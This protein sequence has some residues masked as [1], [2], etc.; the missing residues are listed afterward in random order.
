LKRT[1]QVVAQH[2][3]Q[4]ANGACEHHE[5]QHT[6]RFGR[7]GLAF[8]QQQQRP[9]IRRRE[10]DEE[11]NDTRG[12]PRDSHAAW[13]RFSRR[14]GL[15]E[16]PEGQ[17]LQSEQHSEGHAEQERPVS[18]RLAAEVQHFGKQQAESNPY[19]QV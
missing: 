8:R 14:H 15:D 17:G 11:R 16:E 10:P 1:R 3:E 7:I 12:E 9:S 19:S 5:G 4:D 13:G 18:R 2:R 6:I